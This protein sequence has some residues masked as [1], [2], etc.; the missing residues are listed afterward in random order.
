MA[1]QAPL[2]LPR[3]WPLVVQSGVLHA[4][5]IATAALT[6]AWARACGTRRSRAAEVDRLRAEI[7]LLREE[8][9]IKDER[10]ARSSAHK[11]PHYGPVHRLRILQ[12]RAS[13]GWT[14]A[15]TAQRFLVTEDTI[16]GVDATVWSDSSADALTHLRCPGAS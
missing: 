6:S 9:D 2:A 12:L 11:R 5:S 7:A 4:I 1:T 8:L 15:Q 14:T 10:W 16:A 13:R 3:E